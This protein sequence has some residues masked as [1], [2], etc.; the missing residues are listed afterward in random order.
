MI[1][2]ILLFIQPFLL[3]ATVTAIII[4][5]LIKYFKKRGWEDDPTAKMKKTGNYTANGPIPRGAGLAILCGIYVAVGFFLKPDKELWGVMIGALLL[6]VAGLV[7]D[8][9]DISPRVRMIINLL[10]ACTVVFCGIGIKAVSNP[11][12]GII[13][14]EGQSIQPLAGILAIG[15]IV[16]LTNAVGWATGIQGQLSGFVIITASTIG[17]LSLRFSQDITQW[18]VL[19]LA[20]A[21]AGAYFGFLPFNFFPQRILPGYSGKS[22]AGYFL[23]IL[24]ILAG[25]KLATIVMVLGIPIL[26]ALYVALKRIRNKKMPWWGDNSHFHHQLLLLGWS[27]KKVTVFYWLVSSVLGGLSLLLNSS[28]KFYL[29]LGLSI[30]FLFT[31]AQLAQKNRGKNLRVNL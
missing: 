29:M 18:P 25:A 31:A 8:V 26:D 14:L 6:L 2:P 19:I 20:G 15:W 3:S 24:G 21:V 5:G 11:L 16:Y 22:L 17:A 28:Q 4:P 7:D 10:A 12:G 23:A 13:S 27:Q 1:T 9:F 30:L